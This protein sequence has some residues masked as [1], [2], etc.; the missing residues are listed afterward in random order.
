MIVAVGNLTFKEK[1]WQSLFFSEE[2]LLIHVS[3]MLRVTRSTQW[4]PKW[5]HHL[6]LCQEKELYPSGAWCQHAH[7]TNSKSVPVFQFWYWWLLSLIEYL[8]WVSSALGFQ[9]SYTTA[10]FTTW[11]PNYITA[12]AEFLTILQLQHDFVIYYVILVKYQT[13]WAFVSL[14]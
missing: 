3:H 12:P 1:W 10:S 2:S 6:S 7:C 13:L 8:T 4:K 5:N 9:S 11:V 14:L